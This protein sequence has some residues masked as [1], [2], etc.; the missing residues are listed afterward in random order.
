MSHLVCE[1]DW[2][3]IVCFPRTNVNETSQVNCPGYLMP[4]MDSSILLKRECLAN[5]TWM[6][7]S[8]TNVFKECISIDETDE[9]RLPRNIYK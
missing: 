6:D 1:T 5:G 9:E 8:L 4:E 3:G 2:A 7:R